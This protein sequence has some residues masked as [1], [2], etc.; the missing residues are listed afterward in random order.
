MQDKVTPP[1]PANGDNATATL[2][3]GA[4]KRRLGVV[5]APLAIFGL[6]AGL[7]AFALKT[8]DP[9][10]LPSALIG[11]PAPKLTLAPL[12]GVIEAGKPVAGITPADIQRGTPVVLNFW[13]SWCLPCL[14]E[15][16]LL[17]ELKQKHGVALL[18]V[19]HK[20]QAANARRFLAR[21]G[22]PFVAIGT[23]G[24]G[25]AAIEWGVYGMPE[26]F[27]IDGQGTVVFKHVGPL[28]ATAI[29][30]KLLPAL[31]KAKAAKA[32]AGK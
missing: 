26:T 2:Q 25:R 1:T 6:M 32:K 31:A 8:G 16:P 13:G 18:G 10:K 11:R 28:N 20:D 19:N 24:D 9:S 12:D 21:Y 23:D 29:E 5:L 7:F 22:N 4:P 15:H 14:D 30:T 27:V 17:V 3:V